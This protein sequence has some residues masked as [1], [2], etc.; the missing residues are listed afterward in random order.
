LLQLIRL[1]LARQVFSSA[2]ESGGDAATNG[3]TIEELSRPVSPDSNDE[4]ATAAQTVER[5]FPSC[6]I[7]LQPFVN[8]EAVVAPVR[9]DCHHIFH[10]SCINTWLIRHDDCPYCRRDLFHFDDSVQV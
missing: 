1:N 3:T 4:D 5:L 10:K 7:C 9:E 2:A 8:G 6:V